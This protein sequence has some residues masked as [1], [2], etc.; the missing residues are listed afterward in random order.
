MQVLEAKYRNMFMVSVELPSSR[1]KGNTS[2]TALAYGYEINLSNDRLSFGESVNIII[3]DESCYTC[4]ST[5]VTCTV[6]VGFYIKC[7]LLIVKPI[8]NTMKTMFPSTAFYRIC[9]HIS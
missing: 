9:C 2:D 7:Y 8:F 3:Y 5:S 1:R 4:N 6:L